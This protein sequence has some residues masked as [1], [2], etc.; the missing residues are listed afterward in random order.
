ATASASYAGATPALELVPAASTCHPVAPPAA[1]A[2]APTP[3][4]PR[5]DP[6]PPSALQRSRRSTIQAA[7]SHS[8]PLQSVPLAVSSQVLVAN[9][10]V[11]LAPSHAHP[12]G[13]QRPRSAAANSASPLPVRH[14][15]P[16]VATTPLLPAAQHAATDAG[17]SG[18]HKDRAAPLALLL[19]WQ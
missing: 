11:A 5:G 18:C 9:P 8:T 15:P 17:D 14:R 1:P 7:T 2:A 10:I 19:A 4:P 12:S 3:A 16:T 13:R 6:P